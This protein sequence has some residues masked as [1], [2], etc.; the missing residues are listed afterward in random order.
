MYINHRDKCI[1]SGMLQ[2]EGG[3]YGI[4]LISLNN[5]FVTYDAKLSVP[6]KAPSYGATLGMYYI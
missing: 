5:N 2:R 3:F 4:N 6:L 1:Q